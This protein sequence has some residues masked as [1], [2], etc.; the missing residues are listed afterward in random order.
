[1]ST[2][3]RIAKRSIIGTRVCA[4]G[5]DGK[6]Y[7]G[8]IHAVKTPSHYIDPFATAGMKYSIRFDPP[9]P[10]CLS[11]NREYKDIELIG[12]GFQ[13]VQNFHLLP[14]QKVYLTF[15]GREI[16]GEIVQHDVNM[17][18]VSVQIC[19]AGYEVRELWEKR[20]EKLNFK[21]NYFYFF[22]ERNT[23]VK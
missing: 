19:P 11:W 6:F 14:G 17:D 22:K 23:V 15:N 12:P 1:M 9:V 20:K 7:S 16:S 10:N 8:V 2:G 3:K 13:S 18:E 5:D 4:P 21:R